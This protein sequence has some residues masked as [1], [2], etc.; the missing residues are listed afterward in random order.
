MMSSCYIGSK[1][2]SINVNLLRLA[3]HFPGGGEDAGSNLLHVLPDFVG[4]SLQH[5][6]DGVDPLL[7]RACPVVKL[8]TA[9][10]LRRFAVI[11]IRI[12]WVVKTK[13]ITFY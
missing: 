12:I 13:Y 8:G 7:G 5:L 2:Q 3:D 1:Y 6:G 9:L 10:Q 4:A 11:R